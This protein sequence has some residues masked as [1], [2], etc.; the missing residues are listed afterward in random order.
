MH[1]PF[2]WFSLASHNFPSTWE[3]LNQ[4][5]FIVMSCFLL[6]HTPKCTGSIL[7]L[8]KESSIIS[9]QGFRWCVCCLSPGTLKGGNMVGSLV[10]ARKVMDLAFADACQVLVSQ[11]S[12]C[13][14][15][16]SQEPG[17]SSYWPDG[18]QKVNKTEVKVDFF[19]L[20]HSFTGTVLWFSALQ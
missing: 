18:K 12:H 14:P 9:R 2:S 16:S 5:H 3:S 13:P 1:V 7:P 20:A 10:P 19:F 17:W 6:I 15:A 8:C 11:L 4:N